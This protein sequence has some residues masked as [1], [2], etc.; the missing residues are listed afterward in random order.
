MNKI[1]NGICGKIE[2][3]MDIISKRQKNKYMDKRKKDQ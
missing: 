2:G 1:K 3:Q